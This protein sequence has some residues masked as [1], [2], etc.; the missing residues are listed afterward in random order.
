MERQ[1]FWD[2]VES[3]I[4]E[5][6]PFFKALLIQQNLQTFS[7]FECLTDED[8]KE[9]IEDTQRYISSDENLEQ[10]DCL[11]YFDSK[12]YLCHI[13][14]SEID[15][16]RKKFRSSSVHQAIVEKF[17]QHSTDNCM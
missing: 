17:V 13:K 4:G 5:V 8:L 7:S 3:K 2:I 11:Q 15:F 14:V 1:A 9:L 10:A 16:K 6:D 12:F